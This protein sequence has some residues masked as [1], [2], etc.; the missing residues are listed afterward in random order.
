MLRSPWLITLGALAVAV[1]ARPSPAVA[2]ECARCG[3]FE[4]RFGDIDRGAAGA[5]G[6]NVRTIIAVAFVGVLGSAMMW[7]WRRP[8][9]A[10]E[11]KIAADV[12]ERAFPA[13]P[14]RSRAGSVTDC[15]ICLDAIDEGCACRVL[16]CG[17]VFHA[18][19]IMDWWTH[20]PRETVDCPCC[21]RSQ[22]VRDM[23]PSAASTAPPCT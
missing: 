10:P 3:R 4:N 8:K 12:L 20:A 6:S 13:Q 23:E 17:H 7:A 18:E 15:M 22:E 5:T 19:C 21:R 9:L 2:E 1:S 16:Q 14:R 11:K